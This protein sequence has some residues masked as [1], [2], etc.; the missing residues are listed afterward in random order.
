MTRHRTSLG[1]VAALPFEAACFTRQNIEP[2]TWRIVTDNLIVHYTGVGAANADQAA[3]SLLRLGVDALVSWGIAGGLAPDLVA[4]TIVL[5]EEVIDAGAPDNGGGWQYPMGRYPVDP[6]WH[7]ALKD[8]LARKGIDSRS[9][10]SLVSTPMVQPEP[11]KKAAL[12]HAT[13]AMAVD[14]ESGAVAKAAREAGRPF[15]VIRSISDTATMTLPTSTL[16]A[17]DQYGRSSLSK[18]FRGLLENP[19]EIT[20]YPILLHSLAKAKKGLRRVFELCG[21]DLA[22]PAATTE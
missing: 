11:Q 2:G 4:G 14:M 20:H 6:D 7:G 3:Q 10:G 13:R 9:R 5:P 12:H 19:R 15:I 8:R 16:G 22:L 18:L 21:D 17:T 1:I